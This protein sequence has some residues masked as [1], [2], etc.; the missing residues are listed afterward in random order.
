MVADVATVVVLS[1][2]SEWLSVA[3]AVANPSCPLPSVFKSWSAEPSEVGKSNPL[4][5]TVP[6]PFP[7][8][9]RFELDA[10]V[11]T[12]LSVTVT[13]SI[14]IES[15]TANV[16]K[17]A[18]AADDAPITVPSMSP[19]LKSALS[20][21]TAPVPDAES[22]RSEFVTGVVISLSVMAGSYTHLTLPTTPYV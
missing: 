14:V 10:F 9:S 8:S 15:F 3:L 18:A 2:M 4:T 6:E 13:P 19:P 5:D 20:I 12:V 17:V 22:T 21:F 11:E 16:E 1:L 7:E